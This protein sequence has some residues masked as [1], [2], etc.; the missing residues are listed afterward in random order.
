M[1]TRL[2]SLSGVSDNNISEIK[3]ITKLFFFFQLFFS[4]GLH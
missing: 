1:V 2:P 3:N 4:I